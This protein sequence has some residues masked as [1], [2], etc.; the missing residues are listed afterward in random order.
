MLHYNHKV[1]KLM[2][3]PQ[4]TPTSPR[5]KPLTSPYASDIQ[6]NFDTIMPPGMAPLNIFRTVGHNPRVLQRMVNGGLLDKGSITVNDRE[7]IILRTCGLCGAEYEWGVHVASFA[8]KAGFSTSQINDTTSATSNL[9]LWSPQQQ[10]L[11][12]LSEQLHNNQRVEDALWEKLQTHY[13]A[14]QLIELVM[15]AGLYHAV[16]FMVNACQITPESF[17]PRFPCR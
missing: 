11:I 15:V 2:A 5:I 13:Q 7:L 16:S 8:G 12:T 17:A 6:A 9:S 1:N 10:L 14:D 3:N 4:T